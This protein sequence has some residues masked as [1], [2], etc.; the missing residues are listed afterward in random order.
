VTRQ[1]D[2]YQI[3]RATRPL[4]DLVEDLSNWYVRR[5]RRRFWKSEDDADKQGAYGTLHYA[6]CVI[7]QMLAP[8][9]P[10]MADVMWRGLTQDLED[11]PKSVHLSDWPKANK[12]DHEVI[13]GMTRARA[14]INEALSQRAAA[15]MKVRQPLALVTV[16]KLPDEYLS[17]IAEEVNVK[18][19]KWGGEAVKLDVKL[20]P[21]LRQEGLMRD[22][23]RLVQN[24]RKQAGLEIDDRIELV[25]EAD[26]ELAAAI[27]RFSDTIK[28]ETLAVKLGHTGAEG[29]VPVRVGGQ[30]LKISLQKA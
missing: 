26:G 25:L 1:A 24:A 23:V 6:L 2:R 10:F 30:E 15:G 8:W 12:A 11:M 20:T 5:S 13:D 16:P 7:A 27:K 17:V 4:R 28:A 14:Y 3:A 19:V 21:E 29:E 22:V 18:A 9:S